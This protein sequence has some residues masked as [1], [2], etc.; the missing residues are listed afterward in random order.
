MPHT[1]T[2]QST[3]DKNSCRVIGLSRK[4]PSM[5][6]VTISVPYMW[7]PRLDMQWCVPLI[8]TPTPCGFNT[9]H[10]MV[11]L[12]GKNLF[13]PMHPCDLCIRRRP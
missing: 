13:E 5:R 4:H 1:S 8:T 12:R 6:L 2:L 11:V 7:T 3:I 10:E 9:Y